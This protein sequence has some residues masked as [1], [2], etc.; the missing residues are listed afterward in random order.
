MSVP[1]TSRGAKFSITHK[2]PSLFY[3]ASILNESE[4]ILTL[5]VE[6]GGN[7]VLIHSGNRIV[8][9]IEY[10]PNSQQLLLLKVGIENGTQDDEAIINIGCLSISKEDAEKRT[11]SLKILNTK[12]GKDLTVDFSLDGAEFSVL[13]DEAPIIQ[14][15]SS[16]GPVGKSGGIFRVASG[17]R[18]GF[19]LALASL[20]YIAQVSLPKK[21]CLF[22]FFDTGQ[23]AVF[24][25]SSISKKI[26]NTPKKATPKK[27]TPKAPVV[28]AASSEKNIV[29]PGDRQK[30]S[31]ERAK[32][33]SPRE[34]PPQEKPTPRKEHK[35]REKR[36]P[37]RLLTEKGLSSK[38]NQSKKQLSEKSPSTNQ[39]P[40]NQSKK[41]LSEKSLSATVVQ[42][43]KKVLLEKSLTLNVVQQTKKAPSEKL[44]SNLIQQ[45]KKITTMSECWNQLEA[46]ASLYENENDNY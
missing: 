13:R 29:S 42:Q 46:L 40:I 38:K 6:D 5:T 28:V 22:R 26:N 14:F 7:V 34:K 20:I 15:I 43:P 10:K 3:L 8:Y 32:T 33:F 30:N 27:A 36:K 23:K 1:T 9:R 12:Y 24:R 41:T 44:N 11:F 2:N 4:F 45:P 35:V 25:T 16:R 21:D 19:V 18:K 31:V 39:Q 17:E 37:K